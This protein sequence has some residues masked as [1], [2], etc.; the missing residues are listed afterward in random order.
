MEKEKLISVIVPM[1]NV[2]N[3]LEECLTSLIEQTY[4]NLEIIVINDGSTDN[5]LGVAEICARRDNR[6]R[7]YNFEN[8]GLSEARNRGLRVA[9]GDYIAFLD[10]D[11]W[12]EKDMYKILMSYAVNNNCDMVKCSV[13]EFGHGINRKIMP[14][15]NIITNKCDVGG[16]QGS[17]LKKY[18]FQDFL[19]KIACNGIYKRDLAL[20]VYFPKGLCFEDNYSAGMYLFYASKV[21]MIDKILYNYRVNFAGI[22]KSGNKRPLDIAIVTQQLINDLKEQKFNENNFM[23]K[24]YQKMARELFHFIRGSG[25]ENKKFK[26]IYIDKTLYEWLI[27]KLNF[28][29]RILLYYYIVK[30]NIII[31]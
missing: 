31:F 26:L 21:M 19:W 11:D 6:I 1:Y 16:E 25:K 9:Q 15:D 12:V 23:N 10:S 18:Y 14:I 27:L 24:L 28:R 8:A 7:I 17:L 20:K 4:T 30:N 2:E 22:S 3:Y 29:R 5:S 13:R